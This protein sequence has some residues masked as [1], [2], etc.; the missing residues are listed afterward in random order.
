MTANQSKNRTVS[1]KKQKY[2]QKKDLKLLLLPCQQYIKGIP[3]LTDKE[4]SYYQLR[5]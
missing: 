5:E 1:L 2:K 4:M 3:K